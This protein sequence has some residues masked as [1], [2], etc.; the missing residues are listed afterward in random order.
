MMSLFLNKSC[1]L[2]KNKMRN[3]KFF[4]VQSFFFPH[5]KAYGSKISVSKQFYILYK[6]LLVPHLALF[7]MFD[8]IYQM[9]TV[10]KMI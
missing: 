5:Y 3:L 4:S 8:V 6:G 7:V 9:H 1:I 2:Y 10:L